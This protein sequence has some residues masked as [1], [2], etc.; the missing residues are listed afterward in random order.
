M[1]HSWAGWLWERGIATGEIA[2]LQSAGIAAYLCRPDGELLR[3]DLSDGCSLG[4][5]HSGR[6]GRGSRAWIGRSGRPSEPTCGAR[7][8]T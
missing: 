1:H 8:E 6:R 2:P 5:P 4:R 7:I 3:N